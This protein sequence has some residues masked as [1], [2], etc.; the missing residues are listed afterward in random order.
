[1]F[2]S[3]ASCHI[4]LVHIC[5]IAIGTQSQEYNK[6]MQLMTIDNQ[7]NFNRRRLIL[8]GPLHYILKHQNRLIHCWLLHY[9]HKRG[10]RLN[11]VRVNRIT[12]RHTVCHYIQSHSKNHKW[13]QLC[14]Y[15]IVMILVF[16][17][18]KIH[19]LSINEH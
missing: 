11:L 7:K 12:F 10:N 2:W 1:M 9:I 17:A 5:H 4:E 6:V 19:I 8:C 14:C 16:T 13:L 3:I 15:L 18:Q